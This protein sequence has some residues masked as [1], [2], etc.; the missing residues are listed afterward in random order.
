MP[1]ATL[2]EETKAGAEV[3]VGVFM[4]RDRAA[5]KEASAL[6]SLE[7][8][9]AQDF[10]DILK[11]AWTFPMLENWGSRQFLQLWGSREPQ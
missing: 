5:H 8:R 3:H 6:D 11:R 10:Q 2:F 9:N 4:M 7:P 1:A